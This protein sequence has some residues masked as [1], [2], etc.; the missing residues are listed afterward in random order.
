MFFPDN[1]EYRQILKDMYGDIN[2]VEFF[3]GLM[4]ENRLPKGLF[5]VTLYDIVAPFAL[6]GFFSCPILSPEYF[7]PSTYGGDV[8]FNIVMNASTESLF[9]NNIPGDCPYVFLRV[10]DD[11]P[12]NNL[13]KNEL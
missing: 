12:E 8:G 6:Q 1:E 3:V 10:P 4:A 9:C 2:G 7:K 13:H 5:G 11:V